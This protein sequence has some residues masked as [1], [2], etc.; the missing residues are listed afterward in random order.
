VGREGELSELSRLMDD[1]DVRVVSVIGVGGI[2]K[3]RLDLEIALSLERRFHHGA[4]VVYLSAITTYQALL[5]AVGNVLGISIA[6][7]Q[8]IRVDVMNYLHDKHL[9]LMP[10]NVEQLMEPAAQFVS[11][12]T[13]SAPDVM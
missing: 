7:T 3:T 9:L 12:L 13:T 2:G 6:G 8:D 10:D 11:E 5:A 4:F 1:P